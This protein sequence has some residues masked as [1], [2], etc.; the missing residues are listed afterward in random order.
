[1]TNDRSSLPVSNA[2]GRCWERGCDP[3]DR[4]RTNPQREVSRPGEQVFPLPDRK[5][6]P[7]PS[8]ASSCA[9]SSALPY[10]ARLR[11]RA[12]RS[13]LLTAMFHDERRTP[14]SSHVCPDP[15]QENIDS[16]TA[17]ETRNERPPTPATPHSSVTRLLQVCT[18]CSNPF[19]SELDHLSCFIGAVSGGDLG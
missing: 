1:M 17:L 10:C 19:L 11:F 6:L 5:P 13:G 18:P 8:C 14:L 12:N 7:N 2:A 9:F 15:L 16:Q 3:P 4:Q